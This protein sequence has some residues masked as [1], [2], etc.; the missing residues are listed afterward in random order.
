MSNG[1]V[2]SNLNQSLIQEAPE[3]DLESNGLQPID[4][5]R[6]KKPWHRRRRFWAALAIAGGTGFLVWGCWKLESGLP[7]TAAIS[8]FV[9]DGT[10]TIKGADG[11]TL[12]QLGPATRDKLAFSQIPPLLVK[13]FVAS[14][15]HRFYQHNG[16]DYQ[17]IVR[18]VAS[19]L[20]AR[21]VVEEA[22]PL[23]NSSRGL[24]T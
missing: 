9:R 10:L 5:S 7:D 14:E 15:D 20:L 24:S 12:Q 11:S 3:S 6:Y 23:P 8:S 17:S 16:V 4:P 13:A 1:K 19:N 21:N 18:A 22:A 2:S